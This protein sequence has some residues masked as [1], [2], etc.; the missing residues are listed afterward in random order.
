[1]IDCFL[2]VNWFSTENEEKKNSNVNCNNLVNVIRSNCVKQ[3][4]R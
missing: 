3:E 4:M 2:G 1:M